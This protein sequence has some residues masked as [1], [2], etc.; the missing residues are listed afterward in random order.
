MTFCVG[1]YRRR[2]SRPAKNT[3]SRCGQKRVAIGRICGTEFDL[4]YL[5]TRKSAVVL[6]GRS[7]VRTQVGSL[8][9][10]ELIDGRHVVAPSFRYVGVRREWPASA[11]GPGSARRMSLQRCV[12]RRVWHGAGRPGAL[13]P[14]PRFSARV[15][16]QT[17]QHDGS[18]AQFGAWITAYRSFD[19][20]SV[21]RRR[22]VAAAFAFW[23]R[24]AYS[25]APSGCCGDPRAMNRPATPSGRT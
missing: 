12:P 17:W 8:C 2:H 4:K 5:N 19:G 14:S 23:Q 21:H 7:L 3:E 18:G 16:T 6:I 24:R 22:A 10:Q 25:S 13:S 15:S 1:G 20:G 9:F 11:S